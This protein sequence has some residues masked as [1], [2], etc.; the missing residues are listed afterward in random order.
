VSH[1][2]A[3]Y[4]APDPGHPL[5]LAG[6]AWLGRDPA[7]DAASTP[8][9]PHRADPW[10]YGFHATL[11]PPMRLADGHN[12]AGLH[13]A[14][15]QLADRTAGFA[16]P[17]LSVQWLAGFLALQPTRPLAREHALHRL[18]DACV[19][20]LDA[21][22]AAPTPDEMQRRRVDTLGAAQRELLARYGYPHV[23]DH[24]RFHMTLS[25][26]LPNDA[27][28]RGDLQCGAEAHFAAALAQPL[29]CDAL[30]LFTEAAPGQP[31][32]LVRRYPLRAAA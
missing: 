25:D 5:W 6:C 22:R 3:V 1:R 32:R 20:G 18:A 24:W 4:Y 30:C 29:R 14:L 19:T 11:K 12:E 17:A 31:F 15:E 28:L 23:L 27:E 2:Y 21:F 10:R 8:P 7:S 26:T 16:M 9:R 13:A